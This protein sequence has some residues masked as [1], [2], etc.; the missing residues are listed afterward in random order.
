MG[1]Y[2]KRTNILVHCTVCIDL[3]MQKL[4]QQGL[5]SWKCLSK[6]ILYFFL[7]R[8]KHIHV[9]ECGSVDPR[10]FII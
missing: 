1:M 9:F 7:R 5:L 10:K 8:I 6:M 3:T 4:I 2:Q